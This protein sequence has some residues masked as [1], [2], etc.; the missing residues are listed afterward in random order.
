MTAFDSK[1]L[2]RPMDIARAWLGNGYSSLPQE[3]AAI[4]SSPPEFGTVSS[5]QAEPE[6]RL[7]FDHNSGLLVLTEDNFGS[8]VSAIE[9]KADEP[10]GETVLFRASITFRQGPRAGEGEFSVQGYTR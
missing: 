7:H 3:V 9:G 10:Y 2:L 4:L 1:Q 5:W 6:A 8:Y